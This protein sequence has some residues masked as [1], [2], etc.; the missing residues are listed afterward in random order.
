MAVSDDLPLGRRPLIAWCLFDW[1]NSAFPTIVVTFITAAYVTKAVAPT[2]EQ[3][4]AAWG[5]AMGLSGLAVALLGPVLGAIADHGGR[6]KPWLAALSA[7]TIVSGLALW[8]IEPDPA[9]LMLALVLAFFG[10][11]S[12]ELGT[13]FYNAMLPEV[14]GRR[15]I[16]RV[17]GWA[18][19]LGYAGGLAALGL[20]LAVFVLP[21]TPPFGLDP[22]VAEEVRIAA[23]VVALWFLLFGLPL[24][25]F[26][27]DRPSSGV[28]AMAAVR[29]GLAMLG[30]SLKRL[31]GRAVLFR[32]LIARMLYTDGLNTL[33]AFGGIYAAGTFG[34]DFQEILIFAIILNVTSGLGAL[35]FAWI[36]DFWGPKPT[37]LV[38][39]AALLV[40][41]TAVLLI[42]SKT[43]FYILAA[44]VGLFIGPAQSASRSL[45]ARLA[46]PEERTEMFGL[47]A[48]SGRATA[49]LGP[50]L[51]G[52]VTLAF[53]NQRAGMATIIVF[54]L[55]GFLLLAPLRLPPHAQG[56][57]R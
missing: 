26:V 29:G 3:G 8:T 53:D 41:G 30:S 24:F 13:V 1:A 36:D 49:F 50:L 15:M 56:A 27:P 37:I 7:I 52:W 17:S 35:A 28:S 22:E 54:F 42:E 39:L 10:S 11:A 6:R 14:A 40:L 25:L 16:G 23:P 48:L 57:A 33:F 32:F 4:T 5:T 51:V 46:E 44:A 12:F 2:P 47:Y 20:C 19:A 43:W 38:S 21:E 45:M 34:M 31:P 18:W 55:L 9:F